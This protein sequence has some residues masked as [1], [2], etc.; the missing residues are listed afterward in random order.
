MGLQT[1]CIAEIIDGS[2]SISSRIS[3][4]FQLNQHDLVTVLVN[5]TGG[6]LNM[7]VCVSIL[8]NKNWINIKNYI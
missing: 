2:V 7:W 3:G 4:S 1:S 6:S 5:W 8:A